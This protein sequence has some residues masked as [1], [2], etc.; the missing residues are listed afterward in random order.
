[1]TYE[2]PPVPDPAPLEL[3]RCGRGYGLYRGRCHYCED[4]RFERMDADER[5]GDIEEE[6]SDP[7]P[8]S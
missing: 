5:R 1:M 6:D 8:T 3:C 2:I 4:E 7:G